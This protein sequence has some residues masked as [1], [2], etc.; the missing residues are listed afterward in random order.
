M[1]FSP[2]IMNL[3]KIG[4]EYGSRLTSLLLLYAYG[5]GGYS[6]VIVFIDNLYGSNPQIFNI[7]HL[8]IILYTIT[9]LVNVNNTSPDT[10]CKTPGI[11]RQTHFLQWWCYCHKS[12]G[13]R[14]YTSFHYMGECV[15]PPLP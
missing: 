1:I 11:L 4:G 2:S 8:S 15:K 5:M 12:K 6:Y 9:R 10:L 7:V 13:E 14:I 3:V